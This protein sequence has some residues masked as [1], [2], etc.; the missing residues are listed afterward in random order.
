MVP[1]C[2]TTACAALVVPV[3]TVPKESAVGP[4]LTPPEVEPEEEMP[5]PV[6]P[7]VCGLPAAL[8]LTESVPFNVPVVWGL[9]LTLMV[10]LAFGASELPH[11]WVSAKD[12]LAV[13]PEMVS[14]ALPEFFSVTAWA[15]LVVPT[16]RLAKVNEVGD[17]DATGV[18]D[19]LAVPKKSD[20]RQ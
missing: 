14:V 19:V 11:V 16:S 4:K 8:S 20:M 7:T 9:K 6:R 3:F 12:P 2:R 13:M 10:Q 1:L 5:E 18:F 17:R 15:A